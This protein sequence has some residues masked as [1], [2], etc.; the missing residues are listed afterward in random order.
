MKKNTEEKKLKLHSETIR[1][2]Q[3]HE[4]RRVVG[5]RFMESFA[6][7]YPTQTQSATGC[8]VT[9]SCTGDWC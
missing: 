7:C 1:H 9:I 8:D 2:L 6:T 4:L 5:G 3:P